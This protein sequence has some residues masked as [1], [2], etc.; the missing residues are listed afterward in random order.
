MSFLA[1]K[2]KSIYAKEM[3][4]K[5][6]N[7]LKK[8]SDLLQTILQMVSFKYEGK[9]ILCKTFNLANIY[10]LTF[11]KQLGEIGPLIRAQILNKMN[12]YKN[13]KAQKL[14]DDIIKELDWEK[15][16]KTK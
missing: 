12:G 1:N 13:K 14:F 4:V 11:N 8:Y 7:D 16:I 6:Q 3:V 10:F 5:E 15:I 2:Y 9:E